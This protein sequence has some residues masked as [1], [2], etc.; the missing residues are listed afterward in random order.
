MFLSISLSSIFI[1]SLKIKFINCFLS[2][3]SHSLV[4]SK[5]FISFS[6]FNIPNISR[7][8]S[9]SVMPFISSIVI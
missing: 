6:S 2:A 5:R 4:I 9:S 7:F 1:S 3:F 8:I